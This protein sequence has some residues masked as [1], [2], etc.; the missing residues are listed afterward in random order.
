MQLRCANHLKVLCSKGMV[1]NVQAKGI[2]I[3]YQVS[4]KKLNASE[5][6]KTCRKGLLVD[7]TIGIPVLIGGLQWINCLLAAGQPA[8][9]RQ[10]LYTGFYSE[11]ERL[12]CWC[13]KSF[14]G[15][16]F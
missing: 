15:S 14:A 4:V 3:R 2:V 8:L 1:L 12:P 7:K 10:E 9:R 16:F 11:R 6:L 13:A 5:S